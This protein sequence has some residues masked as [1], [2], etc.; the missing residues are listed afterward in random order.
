[1]FEVDCVRRFTVE[2]E[3]LRGEFVRLGPAW[4]ALREYA[5]Y[6]PPVRQLLGEVA[7]AAVLLAASLKFE[8]ELTL[9]LQGDGPVSLLVAQCTHD[10]R[11]RAV[12]RFKAERVESEHGFRELA[13]DGRIVVSIESARTPTYQGI[14]AL[15]GQTLA[16]SLEHYFDSSEQLQTAVRLTADEMGTAGLLVQR[17]PLTREVTNDP[18][19]RLAAARVS[20]ASIGTDELLAR[21]VPDILQRAVV[22]VD[23]RLFDAQAVSFQCRC[24]LERVQGML[25]VLG[26]AECRDLL[27]E[28]GGIDITCEF[29]HRP[30]HF[31]PVDVEQIFAPALG[32]PPSSTVVN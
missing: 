1:M 3:A 4:L 24:S 32:L 8:G 26:E 11:L 12:A 2:G 18:T 5:D 9:Q 27:A 28:R 10:F 15:T 23:L 7:T 31:D 13:G 22:G 21:R 16:E 29:C 6:P 17:L 14:V 25:K 30:W 19:A 20:M